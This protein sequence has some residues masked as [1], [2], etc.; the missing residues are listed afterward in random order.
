M[1]SWWCLW[2]MK[3]VEVQRSNHF[4]HFLLLYHVTFTSSVWGLSR[5]RWAWIQHYW[6]NQYP[7]FLSA[8][9]VLIKWRCKNVS[10]VSSDCKFI[11]KWIHGFKILMYYL[12]CSCCSV[13]WW[14][15]FSGH[16]SDLTPKR[17][18]LWTGGKKSWL[19][20]HHKSRK[21]TEFYNCSLLMDN[22]SYISSGNQTLLLSLIG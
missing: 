21:G 12:F 13:G 5:Q 16:R 6:N 3:K 22:A 1:S 4:F 7:R 17:L 11:V 9:L 19:Q 15:T 2:P 14:Y 10:P 8:S 18:W 20:L